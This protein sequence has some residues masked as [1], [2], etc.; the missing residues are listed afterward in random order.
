VNTEGLLV[1]E[2]PPEIGV[3]ER[4]GGGIQEAMVEAEG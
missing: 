4:H 3:L 2:C 1:T